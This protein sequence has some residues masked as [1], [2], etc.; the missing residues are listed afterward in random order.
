MDPEMHPDPTT[1][2]PD[3]FSPERKSEMAAGS[4]LPFGMG[5][6]Q[7]LGMKIARQEAKV[8]MFQMLKNFRLETCDRTTT[9]LQWNMEHV[10]RLKGGTWLKLVPRE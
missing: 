9:P 7:C 1:F 3:R 5:P 2:D 4:Y 10:N 6:R 8:A